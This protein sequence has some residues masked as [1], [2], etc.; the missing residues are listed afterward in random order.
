MGQMWV[1]CWR[2][3]RNYRVARIEE[4]VDLWGG[5]GKIGQFIKQQKNTKNQLC[6]LTIHTGC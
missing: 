3:L 5:G 6:W 2:K 1:E 4:W